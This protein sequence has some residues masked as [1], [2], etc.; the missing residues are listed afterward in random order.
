MEPDS[1]VYAFIPGLNAPTVGEVA[2]AVAAVLAG[3]DAGD[4]SV[5][6][7]SVGVLMETFAEARAR[8]D[9]ATAKAMLTSVQA[10]KPG[11]P[12]VAQQLAVAT[13]KSKQPDVETSLL[14]AHRILAELKPEVSN[15]PETLGIWGAIHKRL[16]DV[17]HERRYLDEAVRAYGAGFVLRDDWY[18]GIN[19][20]FVLDVRAAQS[21][22]DDAIA[23]RVWARRT[24]ARVV[25]LVEAELADEQTTETGEP[26][27][28][29]AHFWRQ[30]TLVEA[31]AGTGRADEAES[32]RTQAAATAPESWMIG[33]LD[34]QLATLRAL[35]A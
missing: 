34:E 22:G 6:D 18:N 13:Y 29:A 28:P 35:H 10:L 16:W 17:A 3:D 20:A 4:Q 32:L 1:P 30:A 15:D 33:S 9:W 7:R 12:F 24:R 5:D 26:L 14:E 23:D 19:Y 2:T 8:E 21:E 25:E 11:D 27:D 31:Y